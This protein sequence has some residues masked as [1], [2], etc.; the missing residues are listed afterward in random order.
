MQ[1][2]LGTRL[3]FSAEIGTLGPEI[4]EFAKSEE[5]GHSCGRIR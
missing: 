5:T 1:W 4:H 2:F 3:N